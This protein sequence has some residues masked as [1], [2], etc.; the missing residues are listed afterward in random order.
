MRR[1]INILMYKRKIY[2]KEKFPYNMQAMLDYMNKNGK[3]SI[4]QLT[5]EEVARFLI[6]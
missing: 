4:S 6:K 3:N 2:K 5:K 1:L